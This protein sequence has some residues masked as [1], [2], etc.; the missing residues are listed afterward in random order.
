MGYTVFFFSVY[1]TKTNESNIFHLKVGFG[2]NKM[3]T[4]MFSVDTS[5]C[6]NFD[7]ERK[8]RYDNFFEK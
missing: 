6:E 1:K 5:A 3:Y 8:N 2:E 7:E 4:Y